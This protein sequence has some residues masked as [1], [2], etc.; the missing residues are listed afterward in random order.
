MRKYHGQLIHCDR[1]EWGLMEVVEDAT[2]RT[3]HFGTS[4]R[5]STMSLAQP[6]SLV[7]TY[8]RAMATSLLFCPRPKSALLLGLGGGSLAKFL[9]HHYIDCIVD[10]VELRPKVAAIAQDYFHLPRER[11]LRV[12][13]CD[14]VEYV[15]HSDRRSYDLVLVDAYLSDGISAGVSHADFYAACRERLSRKGV[16]VLNLWGSD[17]KGLRTAVT[18]ANGAGEAPVLKLPAEGTTN[19]ILMTFAAPPS[20]DV[21]HT[22]RDGARALST[23]TQTEFVHY[24]GLLQRAYLGKKIPLLGRLGW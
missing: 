21:W 6:N 17:R 3:L 8:T 14:A 5:Q 12:H 24:A 13:I 9:R 11:Q 18:G 1:D 2:T 16:L 23:N 22:L 20:R 15:R 4:A 10:A 7:L 19:V